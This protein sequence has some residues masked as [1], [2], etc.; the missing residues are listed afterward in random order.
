M[1]PIP[2][3]M[4]SKV[5]AAADLFA[6]RGLDGVKMS[7]IAT[8]TGIPRATLYYHFD[9]KQAVFAYMCTLIFDVFE[10]AV[11]TA[12]DSSGTAAERLSLVIR[13]QIDVYANNPMALQALHLDLGRAA[14][15][16]DIMEQSARSYLR[17]LTKLLEEGVADGSLRKVAK[18]RA[19]AAAILGAASIA[20]EQTLSPK[21][22]DGASELHEAMVSLVLRGLG[23]G[24]GEG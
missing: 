4:A 15:G 9:G 21:D 1:R 2:P 7:D 24:S 14:G 3:T 13:A 5:L 12:L 23:A 18:P 17:P 16:P 10:E 20:A 8:A 19:V 6:E 11:S 22:K